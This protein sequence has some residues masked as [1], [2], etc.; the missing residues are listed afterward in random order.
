VKRSEGK[1]VVR[2]DEILPRSY[3]EGDE[4]LSSLSKFCFSPEA[5][6]KEYFSFSEGS[7]PILRGD[8]LLISA[9]GPHW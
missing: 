6:P 3:I 7:Q 8:E 4:I 1:N 5:C 9:R 2:D